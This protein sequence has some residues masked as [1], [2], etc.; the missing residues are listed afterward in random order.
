MANK[1]KEICIGIL[2]FTLIIIIIYIIVIF[3]CYKNKTF[4]FGNYTAP[5]PPASE[6]PFYPTG[7]IIPIPP[8]QIAERNRIINCILCTKR[9]EENCEKY[10]DAQSGLTLDDFLD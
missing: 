10:C 1:N 5:A 2:I 7:E 9:E 4:V 3:E 6:S 8:E